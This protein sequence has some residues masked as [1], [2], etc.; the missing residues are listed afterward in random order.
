MCA[1]EGLLAPV[2]PSESV[3]NSSLCVYAWRARL[4]EPNVKSPVMRIRCAS[5]FGSASFALQ[6]ETH[7]VSRSRRMRIFKTPMLTRVSMK[8]CVP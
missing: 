1:P 7:F 6:V 4:A 5:T 8:V 2:S 3:V